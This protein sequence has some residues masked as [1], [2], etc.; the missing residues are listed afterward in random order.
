M[1][2]DQYKQQLDHNILSCPQKDTFGN[3]PHYYARMTDVVKGDKVFHY[4][5]GNI[6]ALGT[7]IRPAISSIYESNNTYY[8]SA[9]TH[10]ETLPN[11]LHIRTYWDEIKQL[12]PAEY[13]PFQKNGHDNRGFL[14]PC[15]ENLAALFMTKIAQL[16]DDEQ[17]LQE[18]IETDAKIQTKMRIGHQHYKEKLLELW[19]NECV[20]C[21]INI[22]ELLRAS[23][24]KPWRDCN[25]QERVDPYNG[26]LLCAHHDALFDRGFIS[27]NTNGKL[28]ISNEL[29]YAQPSIYAIHTDNHIQLYEQNFKYLLWHEAYVFKK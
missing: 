17:V 20:L 14:Y 23:H 15:D 10:Y 2:N 3:I 16:N 5:N 9:Q 18:V 21:K 19:D 24:A 6:V 7:I 26:L 12:L 25:H 29:L 28:L 4:A 22:P 27:F 1:Q 11:P 13:S 8:F